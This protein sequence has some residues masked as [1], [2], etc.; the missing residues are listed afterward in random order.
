MT[1]KQRLFIFFE[2]L[3]LEKA[4]QNHNAAFKLIEIVLNRTEDELTNIPFNPEAWMY[5]GRIY[6]PQLDS[7]IV[8]SNSNVRRYRAK[9]HYIAIGK[10]GAIKIIGCKDKFIYLDKPGQ[11]GRKVDDL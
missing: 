6:P 5:D 3:L 8:S 11:D 7:E 2:R 10:N 9:G 1:K 4:S